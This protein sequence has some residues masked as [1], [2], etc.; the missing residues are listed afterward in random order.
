MFGVQGQHG[1]ID[2]VGFVRAHP[3]KGNG[4]E[5]FVRVTVNYFFRLAKSRHPYRLFESGPIYSHNQSLPRV[6][7]HRNSPGTWAFT[8]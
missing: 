2:V 8:G 6:A 4:I 7:P 5:H 3:V 1:Q